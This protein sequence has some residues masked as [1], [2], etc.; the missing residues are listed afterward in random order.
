MQCNVCP[1]AV[2]FKLLQDFSSWLKAVYHSIT[3]HLSVC[4]G[5]SSRQGR[6]VICRLYRLHGGKFCFVILPG[7]QTAPGKTFTWTLDL[8]LNLAPCIWHLA[9]LLLG[10]P[11]PHAVG[12]QRYGVWVP[13]GREALLGVTG[14]HGQHN[15]PNRPILAST[16][17]L[18]PSPQSGQYWVHP[19]DG[20]VRHI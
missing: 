15:A 11:P 19:P 20:P 6:G 17:P 8:D 1:A 12:N 16:H 10:H 3:Y 9:I 4:N 5:A 7:N 13:D 2:Q 14:G 18:H